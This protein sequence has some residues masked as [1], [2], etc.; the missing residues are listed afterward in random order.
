MIPAYSV[1]RITRMV[2]RALV[3]AALLAVFC[4]PLAYAQELTTTDTTSTDTGATGG[5]TTEAPPPVRIADGVTIG[6]VSVGGLTPAEAAPLVRAWFAQPFTF[7]LRGR[8]KIATP[9]WVGGTPRV[10]AALASAQA[11][12]PG[13]SISLQVAVDRTR[14]RA[15]VARLARAWHTPAVNSVARLR[16]LRPY[17]TR[18]RSG[19]SVL[20]LETRMMIRHALAA[21]QRGPLTVPHRVLRPRITRSNFG[22]AIVVRRGSHRLYVYRGSQYWRTFGVAVGMP[23]YPT[24]LGSFTIVSK[25]RNPWWYP[26]ATAWAAGASPIPPGPGNPLGTRWMGLSWGGIGIHGTPDSASIGYSASHGCIRMRI[27]EAEWLFERVRI[28]TPVFIVSA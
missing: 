20:R 26:P 17:I 23:Q 28:G 27:P 12:L 8:T 1:I 5:T 13:E 19:Y 11:A 10:A 6:A 24:P 21:H 3:V 18:A 15:F 7:T 25:Q 2:R 16:G 22:P 9:W 14:L 4:V